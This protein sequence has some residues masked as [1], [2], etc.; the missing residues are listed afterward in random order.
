M[1]KYPTYAVVGAGFSGMAVAVQ[2]LRPYGMLWISDWFPY[3]IAQHMR[4]TLAQMFSY[5]FE[6]VLLLSTLAAWHGQK[7]GLAVLLLFGAGT[8]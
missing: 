4:W 8:R 1:M 2:L 6:G 3:G 5:K 7:T